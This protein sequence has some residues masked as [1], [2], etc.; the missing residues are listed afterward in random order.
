VKLKTS[1]QQ[2]APSFGKTAGYRMGDV[3]YDYT[4]HSALVCTIYE[5]LNKA[6]TKTGHQENN[7]ILK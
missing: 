4:S 7:P 5:E 2:R 1:V 6:G 3:V